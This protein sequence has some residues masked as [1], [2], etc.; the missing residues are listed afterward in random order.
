[1]SLATRLEQAIRERDRYE[2]GSGAWFIAHG[3]V[4]H[5]QRD[6]ESAILAALKFTE[7]VERHGW[8][9]PASRLNDIQRDHLREDI[10]RTKRAHYTNL[11]IRING[12]YEYR[13]AD[14]FKHLVEICVAPKERT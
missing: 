9:L 5:I 12:E 6:N 10:K 3:D 8:F 1:M 2:R 13:Q 14:Y 11:Q 7:A 4:M